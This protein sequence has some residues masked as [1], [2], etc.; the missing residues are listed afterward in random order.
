MALKVT[1]KV[2]DPLD[3]TQRLGQVDL[4]VFGARPDDL[5]RPRSVSLGRWQ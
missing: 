4:V 5:P 1:L 3:E 2:A